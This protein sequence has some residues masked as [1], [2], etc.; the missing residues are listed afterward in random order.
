MQL[1]NIMCAQLQAIDLRY[2]K[3]KAEILLD[4]I[5]YD[6]DVT[7]SAPIRKAFP[8]YLFVFTSRI[9][10]SQ[11]MEHVIVKD[12]READFVETVE[13][14]MNGLVNFFQNGSHV[15]EVEQLLGSGEWYSSCL[16]F[17]I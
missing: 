13:R 8:W 1:A 7:I 6:Y 12:Q 3:S 9:V 2:M 10:T 5:F 4:N 17:C 16:I 11:L 15:E 14:E